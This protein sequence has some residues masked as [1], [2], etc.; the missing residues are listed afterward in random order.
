VS[1]DSVYLLLSY[2]SIQ[3]TPVNVKGLGEL[4]AL[5]EDLRPTVVELA[6][7]KTSQGQAFV[8]DLE[9]WVI[10]LLPVYNKSLTRAQGATILDRGSRGGLVARQAR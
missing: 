2:I 1:S 7:G 10:F 3:Q 4:V 5:L 9:R 6:E 8:E